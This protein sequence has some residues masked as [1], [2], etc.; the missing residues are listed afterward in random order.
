MCG[1]SSGA[2]AHVI[3]VKQGCRSRLIGG[4]KCDRYNRAFGLNDD[5]KCSGS[6]VLHTQVSISSESKNQQVNLSFADVIQDFGMRLS[7]A[8]ERMWLAD[9]A[10]VMRHDRFNRPIKMLLKA[11]KLLRMIDLMRADDIQD[12]ELCGECVSQCHRNGGPMS[13]FN[14]AVGSI[15]NSPNV[16]SARAKD[17]HVRADGECR[18]TGMTQNSFCGR[19]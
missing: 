18:A 6:S 17:V 15:E 1:P 5:G 4:T 16:K 2:R 9:L 14:G 19:T 10:H 8:D 13:R 3:A 11:M 12:I 7:Y